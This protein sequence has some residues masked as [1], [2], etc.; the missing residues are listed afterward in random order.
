MNISQHIFLSLSS[1]KCTRGEIYNRQVRSS[2]IHLKKPMPVYTILFILFV[3]LFLGPHPRNLEVSRL[4]VESQLLPPAHTT[5]KPNPSLVFDLHH[6][7][8]QCR[9][10][11]LLSRDQGLSPH[12]CGSQL[13]SLTAEP[14]REL[15]HYLFKIP[16]HHRMLL[17][18]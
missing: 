13:G 5:A 6:N 3:C 1:G 10:L 2:K 9:I 11:N 18:L 16:L 12:P 4:G 8:R 14:Q 7:S 15:L 17:N